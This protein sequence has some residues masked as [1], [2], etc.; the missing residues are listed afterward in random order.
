METSML[1]QV[2]VAV[3]DIII[4]IIIMSVFNDQVNDNLNR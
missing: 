3:E 1:I 4:T 2:L